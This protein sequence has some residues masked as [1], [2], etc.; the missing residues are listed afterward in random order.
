M[1]TRTFAVVMTNT[2]RRSVL[3]GIGATT[4][5]LAGG[6]GVTA[7]D[8]EGRG[9]DEAAIRVAHASPDAPDVDV[10][11]DGS[12]VVS[13]LSFRDVSP[14]LEV[15]AGEYEVAV[16][17][18]GTDTT[19]FGPVD[20]T[21]EAEDYTA[22]ARGEVS[23]D[24]TA[25]TVAVFED[26]NGANVGDDEARVRAIHASPDAP[27]VDVTV[28]DGA[29]TLFDGVAFGES[30]GYVVVEAGTYD[31][32]IRPDTGDDDG[33]VVFETDLTLEGGATYTAFAE[34]YLSPDD[35]STDEAF[36]LVPSQDASAP[37]RGEGNDRGGRGGRGGRGRGN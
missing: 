22:V 1:C 25:F 10:L 16:N 5:L 17:A 35:E 29:A 28:D 27:A 13:D 23:S 34:G 36:G 8:D 14:Y 31:V 30:G 21:L 20:L 32:E 15:P 12:V 26:T 6:A 37:P 2:N 33:S 18:A 19:V 9:G 11:V 3:R 7:A 24:D 4:A